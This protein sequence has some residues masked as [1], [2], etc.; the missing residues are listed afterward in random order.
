[1][2]ST[3]SSLQHP[4]ESPFSKTLLSSLALHCLLVFTVVFRFI[5]SMFSRKLSVQISSFWSLCFAL[6][7]GCVHPS[8][9]PISSFSQSFF[10]QA[11]V[12]YG[13]LWQF[14]HAFAESVV[15]YG[16]V[17]ERFAKTVVVYDDFPKTVVVY[18]DFPKTVVV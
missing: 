10:A 6:C 1:M 13:H 18:D 2:D 12:I 3:E 15:I 11:V 7:P 5:W 8:G 9:G 4:A 14:P 17:F 16:N